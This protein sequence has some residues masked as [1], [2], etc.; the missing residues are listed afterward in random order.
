MGFGHRPLAR[1][2]CAVAL[3]LLLPA[4]ASA[5]GVPTSE[6]SARA[7]AAQQ[8]KDG[9]SAFDRGDFVHAAEAFE[10]AYR[11]RPH[12]DALW[13]AARARERA[14]DPPRA[15]TLY[16]R[17]LREAPPDAP[18]RN[19]ATARLASLSARLGCVE[20][21]GNG[22]EQLSVDEKATDEHTIFVN[23]G[24][25]LVRAV[26]AGRL[27]QQTPVVSPGKV[28]SVVFEPPAPAVPPEPQPHVEPPSST[29]TSTST[30][31]ST[32]TP[33][34]TSSGRPALSPWVVAGGGVLTGVSAAAAIASGLS[35]LSALH[36]FE[37]HPTMSN[38]AAGQSLQARTNVLLG[39]SIG[40]G[41]MTAATA[42]W[43][44]DWHGSS[45]KEPRV[46]FGVGRV[47]ADWRF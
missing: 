16:A 37:A 39:A 4:A 2:A 27:V 31:T 6:T 32:S 40:L 13:N 22:I 23:P 15:A 36:A 30:S 20:V 42:I 1:I 26:V 43:F 38:L 46:G 24:A 10:L 12:V 18:D 45:Q 33:T 11:L 17:Y 14:N 8:F 41:L 44:V 5:Q 9:S 29:P 34:P 19:V 21:H 47:E 35:T 3:G 7:Q 28:F 25:H